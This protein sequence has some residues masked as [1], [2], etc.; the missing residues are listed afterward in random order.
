MP[1]QREKVLIAL[2][3]AHHERLLPLLSFFDRFFGYRLADRYASAAEMRAALLR[4]R[5]YES[6][7]N[8]DSDSLLDKIVSSLNTAANRRLIELRDVYNAGMQAIQQVHGEI[9]VKVQPTYG[10]YQSGYD[11]FPE[12]KRNI[13]GFG[14]LATDSVKFAPLFEIR[15]VGDE[16]VVQVNGELIYRT[17]AADPKFDEPF[18][19]KIKAIYVQGLQDLTRTQV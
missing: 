19:K 4:I 7:M 2:R 12:G 18:K 3:T 15:L 10:Y 13:L 5:Y 16:I 9:L 6:Q 14:R 8:D 11:D 1:H 17:D